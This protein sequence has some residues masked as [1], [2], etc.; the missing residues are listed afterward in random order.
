MSKV[1]RCV[2]CGGYV[3]EGRMVCI[4][5]EEASEEV[6]RNVRVRKRQKNLE[7]DEYP[8]KT[9]RDRPSSIKS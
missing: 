7:Y 8:H 1:D 4:D 9:K 5:C 2:I 6:S 3:P